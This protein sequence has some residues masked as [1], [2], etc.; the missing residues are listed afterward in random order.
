MVPQVTLVQH[1]V[2]S[3]NQLQG[4]YQNVTRQHPEPEGVG[5]VPSLAL[6]NLIRKFSDE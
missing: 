2:Q 5:A 4:N 6:V 3:N 1:K